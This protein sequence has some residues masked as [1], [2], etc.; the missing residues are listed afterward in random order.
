M[1][2]ELEQFRAMTTGLIVGGLAGVIVG[3]LLAPASG[4]ETRQRMQAQALA[5]RDD[6]RQAVEQ[7]R[8][9]AESLQNSGRELLE[10]NKQRITRTV[11]AA[12]D[13]AVVAWQA[14]VPVS[15]DKPQAI[16]PNGT[17]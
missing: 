11:E 8:V 12:R 4:D 15:P 1:R 10:D 5:V 17:H 6:A 13:S 2:Q 7:A 3:M 14:S 9:K 16:E